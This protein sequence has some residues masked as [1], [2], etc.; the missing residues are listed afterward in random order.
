MWLCMVVVAM[1]AGVGWSVVNDVNYI[2]EYFDYDGPQDVTV[3]S[4]AEPEIPRISASSDF[5]WGAMGNNTESGFA[6]SINLE[7]YDEEATPPSPGSRLR[8][9]GNANSAGNYAYT[10]F[11]TNHVDPCV[12]P[13]VAVDLT[14]ASAAIRL[15]VQN[16]SVDQ[17]IIRYMIRDAA[18]DWFISDGTKAILTPGIVMWETDGQPWL[19]IDETAMGDI[20]DALAPIRPTP[21]L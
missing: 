15:D 6:G 3:D 14:D 19:V 17:P 16:W 1:T 10:I 7:V 13:D 4:L 9:G 8:I 11:D 2:V 21:T 18:G 5:K 20:L 12:I